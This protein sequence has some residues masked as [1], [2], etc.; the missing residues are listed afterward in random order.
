MKIY[1]KP[2]YYTAAHIGLGILS[3]W[4][5]FLGILAIAYQLGQLLFNVRVFPLEWTIRPGNSVE[6][7]AL[8]LLE[9]G[10]GYLLG[11]CVKQ[12]F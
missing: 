8:K 1:T 3:V 5:P 12:G 11:W 10:A 9:I 2:W 6:Y 4:Y 7:T